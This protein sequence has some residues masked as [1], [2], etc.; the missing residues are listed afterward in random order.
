MDNNAAS[1]ITSQEQPKPTRPR[2]RRAMPKIITFILILLLSLAAGFGG[3]AL[4][5]ALHERQ[6]G[7]EQ[8]NG[9]DGNTIITEEEENI[10][11]VAAKV[12]PSV[13]SIV[14]N[15]SVLSLRGEQTQ[16]GAGT[17]I[18]VSKDGYIMTN[19]HVVEGAEDIFVATADGTNYEDVSLVGVDPLND[20]AFLK[21][22]DVNNLTPAEIGD[23]GSI[24]IG[25]K[26][27]A[28]GNA[29]GQYQNTVTSGIVSGVGRPVIAQSGNS[30][31]TLTD[32]IQTDASINPGNSGG[33]LVNLAGQ[34][35]GI[36][37]AIAAEANGIGFAIPI[38]ATKGL[39]EGVLEDGE[40][41]RAYLG[42]QYRTITPEV[43][44]AFNLDVT[45]GAYV[46]GSEDTEA[47]VSGS[48]ADRA[49]IQ[50]GDIITRVNGDVV[51]EAGGVASII[52]QY[53]P[54]ETVEMTIIRGDDTRQ[55]QVTLTAYEDQA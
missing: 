12:S 4:Y 3:S 24:R 32:L 44:Q 30:F 35:I 51:G 8:L 36:N 50:E 33:P 45:Q 18:I 55:V 21:I 34:V 38:D 40:V 25:Q 47:V 7:V 11:A 22:D 54:G 16:E 6:T 10:A 20:V 23:S 27:V 42:V 2:Q 29:L 19:K 17:G 37:T 48:P 28:I 39:L 31:E 49:G 1:P 14:T 41:S 43:V 5:D 26:V 15:S 9:V 53:Q 52:G 13:V 46:R